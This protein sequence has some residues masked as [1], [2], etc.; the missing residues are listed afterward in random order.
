MCNKK[1]WAAAFI[2]TVEENGG[3]IEDALPPLEA[4]ASWAVLQQS[5]SFGRSAAKRLEPLIR[6]AILS[7]CGT[8]VAGGRFSASQESVIRFFLLVIKKNKVIHVDS[9][10]GEIKNIL[11]KRLGIITVFAEYA[12]LPDMEIESQISEA[13]K[14]RT[15]A[16]RVELAGAVRTEL[17]GGYRLRIGDEIIDASILG[18]LRKMETTL[19]APDGV[20]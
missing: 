1:N 8:Y 11:K 7:V 4:L 16:S 5:D 18:Q 6:E 10:I 20:S 9:I 15:G 12:F 13:I 2:S 19:A 14:K 3:E 17:I